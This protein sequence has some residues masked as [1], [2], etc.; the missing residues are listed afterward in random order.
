[1]RQAPAIPLDDEDRALLAFERR[2][3]SHAGAKEEAIRR[4]LGMSPTVYYQR[5]RLL[6]D[7]PGAREVDPALVQRL[8][9]QRAARRRPAR[10]AGD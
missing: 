7:H 2:W 6:L 8:Q 10:P 1:M 4:E 9:A 3:W 5:L